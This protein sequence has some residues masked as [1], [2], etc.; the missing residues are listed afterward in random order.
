MIPTFR[1]W[2][3]VGSLVTVAW[4]FTITETGSGRDRSDPLWDEAGARHLLSRT[5]FG[6]TPEEA[7]RL[8]RLPLRQAVRQMLDS[9]AKAPPPARPA[10]VR[11][12][13]INTNRYWSDLSSEEYLAIVRETLS[14]TSAERESLKAWWLDHMIHTDAPLR[15]LMTLFWHGHFTTA[16]SK[17]GS[18][19]PQALYQQNQTWRRHALGNFRAFLHDVTLDPAMLV[20]LDLEDSSREHPNEN[21]ARELLELFALGVGNYSERDILELARALTGWTLDAPP[22]AVRL[23][24]PSDPTKP[25][26][27]LRDG[28]VPRFLPDR[29][30]DGVKT[31]LGKTGRLG[32]K[33]ALDIVVG[34]PACGQHLAGK[35]IAFFGAHDPRGQLRQ[36]MAR[37]F[38]ASRYEIRPM[39]EELL[40]SPE[41]LAGPS[42]GNQVKS[43]VRLLVGA[44]R[45]LQLQGQATP[46]LTQLTVPLGQELF[47][48]PSVKGWPTGTTWINASTLAW[49]VR[50]GET[51]VT[52]KEP[53]PSLTL[54][55]PRLAPLPANPQEAAALTRRQLQMDAERRADKVGRGL[56]MRLDFTRLVPAASTETPA[57]LADRLLS[58]LLVVPPRTATRRALVDAQS[59]APTVDRPTLALTLILASPEYQLE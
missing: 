26:S 16:S 7:A 28:L 50:L 25:R 11:D 51:L 41:F 33:E 13:W 54:G 59:A 45:D 44:C 53:P 8:A 21:Y 20:Y 29:H 37:A 5:S 4:L 1:T 43:P 58:R 57:E 19:A 15:E 42:R 24:R 2:L 38:V 6:G 3:V 12:V 14:R 47:N 46:A 30:D 49:R 27:M 9:A 32:L 36:R 39:L 17:I 10:W 18:L 56:Q 34:Q 22:E 52:G 23:D 35:L 55:R 31:V 40:T 48:P